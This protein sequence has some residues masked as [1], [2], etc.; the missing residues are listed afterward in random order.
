MSAVSQF[1]LCLKLNDQHTIII[2]MEIQLI[3]SAI[4][5]LYL[6]NKSVRYYRLPNKIVS[7]RLLGSAKVSKQYFQSQPDIFVGNA[8]YKVPLGGGH[9]YSK[10]IISLKDTNDEWIT[11]NY[12]GVY[13][14]NVPSVYVLGSEFSDTPF[15]KTINYRRRSLLCFMLMTLIIAV[16]IYIYAE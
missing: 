16:N 7:A 6:L 9:V 3:A 10:T 12:S 14:D 1:S 4:S 2:V 5:S 8:Y 13:G 15:T 11:S